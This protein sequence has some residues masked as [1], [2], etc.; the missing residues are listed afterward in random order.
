VAEKSQIQALDRT[1]P[2][3]VTA[4]L[5]PRHRNQEFLAFLKQVARANRDVVDE[6]V[7]SSLEARSSGSHA[8]TPDRG[9]STSRPADGWWPSC[10]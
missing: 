7:A 10:H 1:I 6:P 4:A 9:R 8:R 5:K 2:E 3:K